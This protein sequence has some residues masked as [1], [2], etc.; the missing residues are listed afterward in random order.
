MPFPFRSTLYVRLTPERL[1]ILE[2]ESGKVLED[3]PTLVLQTRDGRTEML[4]VGR[5]A[6]AQAGQP[7]VSLV[8][9]FRH[10]RTLLADFMVAEQTL[11]HFVQQALPRSWLK[12]APVLVLHPQAMLE[13]GLT[14]VEIRALAELGHGAGAR[15]VFVWA[16]PE[17][18]REELLQQRFSR[19]GGQLLYP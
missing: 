14:Q 4:G 5:Q 3:E 13:G 2:V 6:A 11:R 8:N 16:G 15:K 17:L 9:G 10:P 12:V 1:S 19:A 7:G 18:S